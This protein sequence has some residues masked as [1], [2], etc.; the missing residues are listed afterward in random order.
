MKSPAVVGDVLRAVVAGRTEMMRYH[1]PARVQG[2]CRSCEKYGAYWSCPPFEQ[3]PLDQLPPWTD[4][5]LVTQQTPVEP[6]STPADL[7]EQFL[8]ARERLGRALMAREGDGVV[9]VIAGHCFGCT[10]CTRARGVACC[11]PSRLRYSLEALGFDVTG[12]AEGLAG[13]RI[14]WPASGVP[15][16]LMIVG[17]LLCAGHDQAMRLTDFGHT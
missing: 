1:D 7:V 15:A 14:D 8:V 16:S 11:V 17:A 4:A 10:A 6:G 13:Q 2:Y 3:Q 9:A 5:V 12:L